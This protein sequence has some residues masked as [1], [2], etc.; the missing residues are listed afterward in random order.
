MYTVAE[1]TPD[2]GTDP[3]PVRTPTDDDGEL[4]VAGTL[5]GRPATAGS[6]FNKLTYLLYLH[7]CAMA[8]FP[9]VTFA[10]QSPKQ[11]E[12]VDLE[13]DRGIE[14]YKGKKGKSKKK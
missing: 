3:F 1:S 14:K 7:Y 5:T 4:P 9:N 2:K 10:F 8:G 11:K 12:R 13:A 6:L